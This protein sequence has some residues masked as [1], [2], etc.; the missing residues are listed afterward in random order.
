MGL[1]ASV[2][3]TGCIGS[4]LTGLEEVGLDTE[5]ELYE[6]LQ[7]LS[8]TLENYEGEDPPIGSA[9]YLD[10]ESVLVTVFL[11]EKN[12]SSEPWDSAAVDVANQYMDI[13]VDYM[14]EEGERYGQEVELYYGEGDL[15]YFADV[16]VDMESDDLE[17]LNQPLEAFLE[18]KVDEEALME[19]YDVNSIG[20]VFLVNGPGGSYCLPFEEG[21]GEQW[22]REKT[23]VFLYDIYEPGVH[24][25]P[26]T[27][28]H[29]IMHMFGAVDLY[30]E[31]LYDG[32]SMDLVE[33]VEEVYPMEIM[34]TTY[35]EVG[36]YMYDYIPNYISPITAY[37]L[38]WIDETEEIENFPELIRE[39]DACFE[40]KMVW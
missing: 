18:D 33:Y 23:C 27:Y 29:E 5:N 24:D 14:K 6:Q 28:A 22:H 9:T 10:G 32:V 12:S 17:E 30:D 7:E 35:T 2:L 26:A 13:A 37:A 39:Y 8:N 25:N 31:F 4:E 21:D 11:D 36:G 38:G 15:Q 20:Y 40:E 19:K 3:L 16:N 34:Y 1:V